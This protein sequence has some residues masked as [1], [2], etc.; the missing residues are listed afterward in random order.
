MNIDYPTIGQRCTG[1]TKQGKRCRLPA[2]TIAGGLAVCPYHINQAVKLFRE[3]SSR[4]DNQEY[5]D[6]FDKA[7]DDSNY[8]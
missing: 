3:V 4:P 1:T 8:Y 5:K 2:Y 6:I 7:R